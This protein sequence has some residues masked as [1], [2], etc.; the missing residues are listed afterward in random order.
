MDLANPITA[1]MV[2]MRQSMVP[3]LTQAA[4]YNLNRQHKGVAIFEVG[5]CF[6]A[7]GDTLTQNDRVG[8]MS[9]ETAVGL[10]AKCK[11]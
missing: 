6:V 7:E 5:Q 8:V 9:G 10:A 11:A 4:G 1:D 2:R 3:G